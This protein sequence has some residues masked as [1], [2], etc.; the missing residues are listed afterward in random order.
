MQSG[1][2]LPRQNFRGRHEAGLATVVHGQEHS[3]EGDERLPATHVALEQAI[4]LPSAPH[5]VVDLVHDP[6]L[7]AG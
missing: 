1:K 2:V 4:H 5:V 7:R 6:L 3:H